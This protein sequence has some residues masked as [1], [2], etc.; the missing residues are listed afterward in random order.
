MFLMGLVALQANVFVNDKKRAVIADFELRK[1][2][3]YRN[4]TSYKPAGPARWMAP[5]LS[6]DDE[7]DEDDEDEDDRPHCTLATDIFAFAMTM[8]EV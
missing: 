3:D 5:E 4:F 2:V 8:I 1:I 6:A 7:D